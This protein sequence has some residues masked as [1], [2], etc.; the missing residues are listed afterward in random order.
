MTGERS[1]GGQ[2]RTDA[3]SMFAFRHARLFFQ[4]SRKGSPFYKNK[5]S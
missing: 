1:P 2:F 4:P 3:E 5:G